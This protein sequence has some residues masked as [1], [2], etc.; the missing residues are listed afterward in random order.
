MEILGKQLCCTLCGGK[1]FR[2]REVYL[3]LELPKKIDREQLTLQSLMC[4][5]CS[6]TQLVQE[7]TNG[8]K[9]NI[10]YIEVKTGW[11]KS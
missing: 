5:V 10:I 8:K 1:V 11:Q 7:Q 4:E 2:H 6:T 3:D 9:T